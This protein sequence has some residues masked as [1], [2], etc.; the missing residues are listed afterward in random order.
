MKF[1]VMKKISICYFS[2][3]FSK[4]YK[5]EQIKAIINEFD[6]NNILYN[7]YTLDYSNKYIIAKNIKSIYITSLPL[8]IN[9]IYLKF[10]FQK[11]YP[12]Y[13]NYLFS[14][15]IFSYVF[16]NKVLK[17]DSNIV[18]LKNRPLSLIKKLK[19]KS[20]KIII[21]ESDQQH[22]FFTN[23][24]VSEELRKYNIKF[25]NIYTD[26]NAIRDYSSSF[27]YADLVVV[28]T[29]KQK[30]I[31]LKYGVKVPIIINELGLE[32]KPNFHKLT[33]EE[34]SAKEFKFISFANHTIL[35]GTHKLVELWNDLP[36]NFS[37]II[38][39]SI[40]ED[41]QEF[42][43]KYENIS[44]NIKFINTFNKNN[45]L[46]LSSEYNLIGISLSLSEAYP[47]VVSEYFEMGIPVVVSNII[48]RDVEKYKFGKV[49]KF[50][51][52]QEVKSA[53]M[54]LTIPKNYQN[55]HQN[56]FNHKFSTYEDFAKKYVKII[57]SIDV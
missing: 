41:F 24:I 19:K 40:E 17:D 57:N 34:I 46:K 50:D 9:K 11:I 45:L 39:G 18:I 38:A 28:Y 42:L 2:T 14:E 54:N 1:N 8:L 53:L 43:N 22:P 47:R 55:Y 15:N 5:S 36:S 16:S 7:C 23:N 26:K 10:K 31:L 12:S 27:E 35:K 44:T 25:K 51:D 37:L 4:G 56:I 6:K 33:T 32:S 20:N 3:L 48:N 49:V 29:D 52:M 13:L 21:L 30:E